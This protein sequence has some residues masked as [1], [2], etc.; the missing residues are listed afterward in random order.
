[1]KDGKLLYAFCENCGATNSRQPCLPWALR[2]GLNASHEPLAEHSWQPI[3]HDS[4]L[5]EM[6]YGREA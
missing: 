2:R 4:I 1:M 6:Y 5:L 3:P